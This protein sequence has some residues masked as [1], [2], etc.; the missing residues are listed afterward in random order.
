MQLGTLLKQMNAS[1]LDP[2]PQSPLFSFLPFDSLVRT[3]A[4]FTTSTCQTYSGRSRKHKIIGEHAQDEIDRT[5]RSLDG[6]DL[7]EYP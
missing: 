3:I 7:Q 4:G 2:R 5:S 1:F 6:L